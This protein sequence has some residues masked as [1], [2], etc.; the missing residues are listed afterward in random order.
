MHAAVSVDFVSDNIF[1]GVER[2]ILC[3]KYVACQGRSDAF[4]ILKAVA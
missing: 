4:S 3:V 2:F 1:Y